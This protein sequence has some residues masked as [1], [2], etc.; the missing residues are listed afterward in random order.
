MALSDGEVARIIQALETRGYIVQRRGE[1]GG[2]GKVVLE[3]KYFRRIDKYSGEPGKWQEWLFNVCVAI[4]S[5]SSEC[6]VAM[7]EIVKKAGEVKDVTT[8][9]VNRVIR[10]KFGSELFGVL[11]SLTAGEANVV[12]RSVV[13]KGAGYCGFAALCLLSQRFNPKTP[14]R[15]LQFLSVILS[16]TPVKDVRLLE[17]AVEEWELKRGTLKVEFGEELSDNIAVAILTSMIPR[18]LQDVVFQMG[19]A[20]QVLKYAAVRDKVMSIAS[21]R[22]QMAVPTPMDIGHVGELDHDHL[23]HWEELEVDAVGKVGSCLRCGGWGH[24]V[25]DCPTPPEAKGSKG[26]GK[27]KGEFLNSW[28]KGG[29]KGGG[30]GPSKGSFPGKGDFG[31][32]KGLKGVGK[33]AGYQGTCWRCGAVGHKAA[34]C[35]SWQQISEV[36]ESTE[37]QDVASVGGVWMIG[38]VTR[39]VAEEVHQKKGEADFMR[40][41]AS[42]PLVPLEHGEWRTVAGHWKPRTPA[43][44]RDSVA[45]TRGRFGVLDICPVEAAEAHMDVAA[46]ICGAQTEIT[47]DSA[48]DESV[49]PHGWAEQFGTTPVSKGQEL[50]LLNASGG[51]INH[52]GSRQVAFHPQAT[53]GRVLGVGFEVTDVKKPLMAVSRIC[54]KGNVVQFGPEA[55]H[56]FIQNISSGEKLFM[57][58]RGNSYVL[59]GELASVNPF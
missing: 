41:E 35:T 13:Q 33:G 54:E 18:D 47:V 3:E 7:E 2:G 11:C 49:C 38:Q 19:H 17:R 24:Y 26:K 45:I 48:A 57:T 23:S 25:R 30:K 1:G 42:T 14:A 21:H 43:L 34:E 28:A 36:A 40:K 55:H 16:P 29:V 22:A 4:S 15:I 52:Y 32:A 9:E 50:K 53:G 58:R 12:V 59:R 39:Q 5:V 27:S 44:Q 37:P 6:V 10:D 46:E 56:N 31:Q 51:K 8:I 20:G